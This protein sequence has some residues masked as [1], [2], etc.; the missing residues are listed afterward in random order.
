MIQNLNDNT[1]VVAAVFSRISS[2][3]LYFFEQSR[4]PL[5][6]IYL[7]LR[8]K[9]FSL[10]GAIIIFKNGTYSTLIRVVLI[11]GMVSTSLK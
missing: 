7:P 6:S 4:F 2:F 10:I 11:T 1:A 5:Q 9:D 3:H 8:Q